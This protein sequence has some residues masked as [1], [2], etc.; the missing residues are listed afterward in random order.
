LTKEET[1]QENYFS[2][3][4]SLERLI[5]KKII[6]IICR[7]IFCPTTTV[8]CT[9]LGSSSFVDRNK[10]QVQ[11]PPSSSHRTHP[12]LDERK[13][14]STHRKAG[15]GTGLLTPLSMCPCVMS[16]L[17][18]LPT[19]PSRRMEIGLASPAPSA[20]NEVQ[21]PRPGVRHTAT[22][23]ALRHP[24]STHTHAPSPPFTSALSTSN[25]GDQTHFLLRLPNH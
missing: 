2:K 17:L 7:H 23:P 15:N 16:L 9:P 18:S 21:T 4:K 8:S 5:G 11:R 25:T 20:A 12:I 13:K 24:S 3:K 14:Q 10:Q 22:Y 19:I 1:G 6:L